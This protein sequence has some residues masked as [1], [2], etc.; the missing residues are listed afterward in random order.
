MRVCGSRSVRVAAPWALVGARRSSSSS[1]PVRGSLPNFGQFLRTGR[2]N[3]PKF[4]AFSGAGSVAVVL[5]S[6][7]DVATDVVVRLG[8]HEIDPVSD[9]PAAVSVHRGGAAANVAA[10]S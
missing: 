10:V 6:V 1:F 3:C 7:G 9:T 2:G 8:G 4:A 5:V